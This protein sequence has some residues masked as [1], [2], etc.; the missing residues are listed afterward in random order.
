M[1]D[2]N[3][4]SYPFPLVDVKKGTCYRLRV[5]MM[6]ANVANYVFSIA[7][8]NMTLVAL[9]GVPVVALQVTSV[10]LHIGERADIVMCADQVG[11]RTYTCCVG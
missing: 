5:I 2:A 9:D 4:S 1:P 3:L 10:N 8:H 11:G 7:G 6:A